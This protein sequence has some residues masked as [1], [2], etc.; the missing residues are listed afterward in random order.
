MPDAIAP[1]NSSQAAS[2]NGPNG[3]VWVTMQDSLDRELAPLGEAAIEALGPR[4]GERILDIGCG[5]GT[6]TLALARVV[7]ASGEALGLDISAPMLALARRRAADAGL[8]QARFVEADAQVHRLEPAA[9]DA[10]YSRF[11]VMLFADP[12][13]AFANIARALKPGGRLAFVCW[14][15]PQENPS[16]SLPL[17]AAAHL[18]PPMPPADPLA[19]G[20][21]AFA[22]RERVLRI[23]A[24]AG[25]AD[26][27]AQAVDRQISPGGLDESVALYTQ[28]GPV[29]RALRANPRPAEAVSAAVREALLPFVTPL[30]VRLDAGV[31]LVTATRL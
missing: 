3:E 17:A 31:W 25:F 23:L 27:A 7:G 16:M 11:G 18:L 30:G 29:G 1:E 4:P 24:Q 2:W 19:P 12:V 15:G 10:L 6:T 13:A 21:F 26:A 28:I 22:D 14:R 9:Y 20:P 8:A 5:C